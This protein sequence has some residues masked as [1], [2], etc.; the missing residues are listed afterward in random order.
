MEK[1][2]LHAAKGNKTEKTPV[3]L[4]RQAGRYLPEYRQIRK[5]HNTLT[6]FKTPTIASEITLQPLNRFALDGA[7]IYADILLIPDAM[8]LQLSFVEKEGPQFEHTIRSQS[9]LKIVLDACENQDQLI[10]KLSYVSETIERVKE[11]LNPSVTLLGFAGAPFTVASYMI[12]GKSSRGEFLET[13]KLLYT[14]PHVFHQ[15]MSSLTL[16]TIAYLEMQIKSGVEVIQLFESWSGALT[17]AQYQEFCLPYMKQIV[18]TLKP[19]IPVICFLGQ[20][21]HLLDQLIEIKP[22]VYSADWRQDLEAVSKNISSHQIALQG[23]LDPIALY[24]SKETISSAVNKC[25]S[26]GRKH[27]NG[28]IFNL[29]HGITQHTPIESVQHII[30]T[31]SNHSN[32]SA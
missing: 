8:G 32:S 4:M 22:S 1:S 20:G 19:K 21:G 31:V 7:I 27:P 11:K 10:N 24:A 9:D 25:L 12:E 26:V 15:L 23:N 18:Q 29:G 14:Q 5:Q 28:Y 30:D 17:S 6:M 13:K 16:S 3:W 2:L